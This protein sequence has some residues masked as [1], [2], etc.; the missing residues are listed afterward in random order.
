MTLLSFK[1]TTIVNLLFIKKIGIMSIN[2]VMSQKKTGND[3]TT[4]KREPMCHKVQTNNTVLIQ[5]VLIILQS[6]YM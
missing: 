5:L 6:K 1:A 3:R 4:K 2:E